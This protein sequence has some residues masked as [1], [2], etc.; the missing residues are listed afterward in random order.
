MTGARLR[1]RLGVVPAVAPCTSALLALATASCAPRPVLCAQSYECK[2]GLTCVAGRCEPPVLDV[3]STKRLVLRPS[4]IA[5]VRSGGP[6]PEGGLPAV[7][8]LG[9][10]HDGLAKLLLRFDVPTDKSAT[11]VRASVLLVRAA[12]FPSGATPVPLRAN[13]IIEPWAARTVSWATSPPEEDVGLPWTLVDT[14][15]PSVTRVDVTGLAGRWLQHE[16]GDKGVAIFA[17]STSA[18]GVTFA[19]GDT[20]LPGEARADE[21][22]PPDVPRLEIYMR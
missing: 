3:A 17:G 18:T 13:A 15:G 19:L 14:P 4:E 2:A 7:V 11:V 6:R 10:E 21:A 1:L 5:V 20:G 12:A 22:V 8:T 9:K 16:R